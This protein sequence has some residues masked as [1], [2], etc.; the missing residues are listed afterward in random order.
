VV[1]FSNNCKNLFIAFTI[2]YPL[3]R[4]YI[5]TLTDTRLGKSTAHYTLQQSGAVFV[6]GML[7]VG[8]MLPS[9]ITIAFFA[10]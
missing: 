10:V 4:P 8:F 5:A 7:H 6:R 2:T 1:Q 9:Q 3:P